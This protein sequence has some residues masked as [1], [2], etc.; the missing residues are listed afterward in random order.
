[1][2]EF[3][4]QFIRKD[5][6]SKSFESIIDR[7]IERKSTTPIDGSFDPSR[8]TECSRRLS[9]RAAGVASSFS[10]SY[11][12]D[13]TDEAIKTKWISILEICP[14]VKVMEAHL[15]VADSKFNI[16]GNIDAVIEL[17]D[18]YVTLIK[19]VSDCDFGNVVENGAFKKDVIEAVLYLWLSEIKN[20]MLIY[21][22]KNNG[23]HLVFHVEP[24]APIIN[25]VK[26]KCSDLVQHKL[27]GQLPKRPYK[28]KNSKECSIC[29]FRDKCWIKGKI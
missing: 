29:E 6:Q 10:D 7:E 11:L 12:N 26:A 5:E 20:G 23:G 19:P 21:D 3:L 22:N 18:I 8:I 9:Y 15:V 13:Q 24:Y 28:N 2:T 25:S 27:M 17:D 4:Q 14:S 1:M 16:T